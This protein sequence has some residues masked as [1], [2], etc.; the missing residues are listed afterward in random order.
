L[1]KA[2]AVELVDHYGGNPLT[3]NV[4]ARDLEAEGAP[5]AR[6]LLEEAGN[7]RFNARFAQRYLYARI[8]GRIRSDDPDL[9]AIAHPGL[10]LR[11]VTPDLIERVLARPC[12]LGE[13]GSGRARQLFDALAQQVWLV[14]ATANPLAVRHQR[15]LRRLIFGS[16]N[17]AEAD[18]AL[19]I[20]A[21][22]AAYYGAHR[23]ATLSLAE[24]DVE[25]LYH[26]TFSD[27]GLRLDDFELRQLASALGED[28]VDL[29]IAY[30]ARLK[31]AQ[32]RG[33]EAD[34]LESLGSDTRR[35]LEE[36]HDRSALRRGGLSNTARLSPGRHVPNPSIEAE[37]AYVAGDLGGLLDMQFDIVDEFVDE[38]VLAGWGSRRLPADLTDFAIWRLA[39][40]VNGDHGQREI[41]NVLID[42]LEVARRQV[43]WSRP[44][45][46]NRKQSTSLGTTLQAIIRL[47]GSN[48]PSFLAER[49][50]RGFDENRVD[51][52]EMLR[53]RQLLR[54][55]KHGMRSNRFVEVSLALLR[56]LDTDFQTLLRSQR[57]GDLS[58]NPAA[59][60]II[61]SILQSSSTRRP[62]LADL[63]RP[64]S[65]RAFVEAHGDAFAN[66]A[67]ADLLRGVSPELYPLVQAAARD[68]PLG[69]LVDF[70][71]RVEAR[72]TQ[73]PREL[74]P[75]PLAASLKRD[76]ERWTGTM[77][78]VAD[79]CGELG[80]LIDSLVAHS[81]SRSTN[82]QIGKLVSRYSRC[83]RS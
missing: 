54:H 52:T 27:P 65:H 28:S 29:P 63:D 44:L 64:R 79:R 58:L 39:I 62:S 11:R 26:R 46:P 57:A 2:I 53:I 10:V 66:P 55:E 6:G 51:T 4:L 75:K 16:M 35:E 22:A 76:R 50:D 82:R 12:G 31:L 18:K 48:P 23:D 20:H 81:S 71:E 61:N 38:V 67:S 5:A 47:L 30:R 69:V 68:N 34:E 8:L 59:E 56:Y 41:A 14:D 32:G 49:F 17:Q 1:D 74:T 42:R 24:Q 37:R 43:E 78:E 15:A 21:A 72:D 80:L 83:L 25:A 7:N 13:I 73:W 70:A 9:V 40:V 60:D 77:I 19:S 45:N 36:S 33:L 3:V